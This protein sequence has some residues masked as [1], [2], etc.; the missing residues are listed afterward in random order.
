M[1][2]G[3]ASLRQE[4]GI[5]PV[6][7]RAACSSRQEIKWQTTLLHQ[8]EASEKRPLSLL[9]YTLV[10]VPQGVKKS[11]RLIVL[12]GTADYE[13]SAHIPAGCVYPFWEG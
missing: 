12:I 8:P 10:G 13:V 5:C 11:G 9:D 6:C 4:Q 1:L 3:L 2:R 7:I